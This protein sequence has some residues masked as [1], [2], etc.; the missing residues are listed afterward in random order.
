V[1][2]DNAYEPIPDSLIERR[3]GVR[4]WTNLRNKFFV[5]RVHYTAD[6]AKRDPK[7]KALQ[8][9]S[10]SLRAWKR[11]YEIDWTSPEG[12][13]VVPEFSASTHIRPLTPTRDRRLLRFW[14]YG[15]QAP[16]CLFVQ[17]S[18][19]GQLLVLRELCP[20][21]CPLDRFI[22]MVF[23]ISRDLVVRTDHFDAGDPSGNRYT[24]LGNVVEI[25]SQHGLV[26]S[27]CRPGTEVSYAALRA[28]FL[29][30]VFIPRVGQD[31]SILI[32]PVGCP[33]LIEA[34]S[35]AFYLSPQPPYRP[36]KSHP[37]KD[38]VDALRYGHDNLHAATGALD[39][40]LKK[41]ATQDRLW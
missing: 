23:A 30:S 33:N 8:Q 4:E 40:K 15:F 20:F 41:I 21:N 13:P 7:W 34:L 26:M 1:I 6:P 22:E 39:E 37:Y 9:T 27:A 10:Y 29:T 32:D 19:Y 18:P 31:P 38:L 24:E 25:L 3:Q 11:E 16:V 36:A 12:E 35:G 17:L 2:P 28:K 14:D 5:L